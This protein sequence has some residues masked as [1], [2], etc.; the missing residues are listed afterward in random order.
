MYRT[1]FKNEII[2]EFLPPAR[3]GKKQELIIICDGMP[4]VP[5][6]QPLPHMDILDIIGEFPGTIRRRVRVNGLSL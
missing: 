1:R 2:A 3:K 4:S 6:K 5:G